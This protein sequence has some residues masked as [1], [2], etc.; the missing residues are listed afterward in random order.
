M[1]PA[2]VIWSNRGPVTSCRAK[3]AQGNYCGVNVSSTSSSSSSFVLCPVR[4]DRRGGDDGRT[5]WAGGG[6]AFCL[7]L[8]KFLGFLEVK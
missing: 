8:G 7:F 6:R 5:E 3:F 4:N 1:Y 2:E